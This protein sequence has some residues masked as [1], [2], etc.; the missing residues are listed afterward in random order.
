MKQK[1]SK[2]V[3]F[4]NSCMS[5]DADYHENLKN[6]DVG[7]SRQ[8][9]KR[10]SENKAKIERITNEYFDGEFT[11]RGSISKSY[12]ELNFIPGSENRPAIVFP[13]GHIFLETFSPFYSKTVDFIIAIAEPCSRPKYMQEYQIS[14]YSLFAAVSIG[15][16]GEKIVHVLSLISKTELTESFKEHVINCCHSVGKLKLVLKDQRYY[17]ES[18]EESLI[19]DLSRDKF[20]S[21]KIVPPDANAIIHPRNGKVFIVDEEEADTIISGVGDAS[22]YGSVQ[23]LTEGF[24]ELLEF[25]KPKIYRFELK[26][27]SVR[28]VRK[29][30]VDNNLFLSDEYDFNNDKSLKN[31]GIQLRTETNIRPYQEK[32]LSKMFSGGRAKSGI[33]VLPC[34]AGKTLVGITAVATVNKS[35]VVC[36]NAG[37]PVKQWAAQFKLW[38]KVPENVVITLTSDHKQQLPEG[39]CILVTTY[40]MLTA[41]SKRSEEGQKV[42]DQITGRDWGILVMDEVQEAAAET[43]RNVTDM[44]RAH[45]RLGLTATM[46]R[47]D[48]KINDLKYL[49]G[50]KLY[51]ANWI[52]LAESGYL[53]RVKCFEILVPMSFE[54][55][56]KY[57]S[58]EKQAFKRDVLAASNPNKIDVLESLLQFHEAR[59]DKILVFCDQLQI[60]ETLARHLDKPA[61]HGKISNK[62]RAIIFDKFKRTREINTIIL[63]KIGDKAIDLPSANVL[64]QLSYH[65]SARMQEAQRLGRVL[66]PKPGRTDEYNAFFYTLVSQDTEEIYY[67][68]KRQAFLIDQGY[69]YEPVTEPLKRWPPQQLK[70]DTQEK[71]EEWLRKM[72]DTDDSLGL[73]GDNNDPDD[74]E[75][76]VAAIAGGGNQRN[77]YKSIV[78]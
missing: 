9:R 35:A 78:K 71:R 62:E 51:E 36:C 77:Q 39:P 59:G 45:T 49:V 48:E 44:V 6:I 41:K 61:L 56:R 3:T 37:V 69:S 4:P 58:L 26:P 13:D 32:A 30:A 47:E 66:R 31:L 24:E 74:P 76:A 12:K 22:Y 25:E 20:F 1:C 16:T 68:A 29:H 54:F 11:A 18:I 53:A 5:D 63:S 15:L 17:I 52:E 21:D 50:P 23:R 10:K 42:I 72:M 75:R 19:L 40:S 65:K 43:F 34:G 70:L 64:I 60:L 55:Y 73:D 14:P 67:S 33:I 7:H 27:S 2:N 46:V 57:L 38:T 8:V 28:D